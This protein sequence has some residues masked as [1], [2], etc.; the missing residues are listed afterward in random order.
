MLLKHHSIRRSGL[1]RFVDSAANEM[2]PALGSSCPV[3]RVESRIE[4]GGERVHQGS[5]DERRE[6]N[7]E[8]NHIRGAHFDMPPP[9]PPLP[10]SDVSFRLSRAELD[11]AVAT[12]VDGALAAHSAEL[13]EWVSDCWSAMRD[14]CAEALAGA[15]ASVA[16]MVAEG[17]PPYQPRPQ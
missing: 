7:D 9:L 14:S 15:L 8:A 12:A 5:N 3:K 6:R 4:G 1:A 16:A 13:R 11:S 17:H 2:R 10:P